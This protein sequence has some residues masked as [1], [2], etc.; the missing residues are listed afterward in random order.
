MYVSVSV[1]VS[2]YFTSTASAAWSGRLSAAFKM[3][4][5]TCVLAN[6]SQWLCLSMNKTNLSVH[7]R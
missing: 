4:R 5:W 1:C 2:Q 6:S 7:Q 3:V